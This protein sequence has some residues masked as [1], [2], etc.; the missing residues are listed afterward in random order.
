M[1]SL[2][3]DLDAI[4]SKGPNG[5]LLFPWYAGSYIESG[6]LFARA[7]LTVGRSSRQRDLGEVFTFGSKN[8][9]S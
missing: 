2:L 3:Q 9:D 8:I 7:K 4:E 1:A 6:K 5:V